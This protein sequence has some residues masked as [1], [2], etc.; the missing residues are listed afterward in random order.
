[1]INVLWYDHCSFWSKILLSKF[2]Q[3]YKVYILHNAHCIDH[4]INGMFTC[5]FVIAEI[6]QSES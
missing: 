5:S 6:G 1:M 2:L 3:S 4:W